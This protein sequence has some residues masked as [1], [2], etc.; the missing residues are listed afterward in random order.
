M[1]PFRSGIFSAGDDYAAWKCPLC[2]ASI[3]PVSVA[4]NGSFPSFPSK[5]LRRCG[6]NYADE[7]KVWKVRSL[8]LVIDSSE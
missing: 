7:A 2:H 6:G 8:E 5:S 3:Q 1:W 4:A